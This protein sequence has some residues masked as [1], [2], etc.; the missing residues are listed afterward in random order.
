MLTILIARNR[1]VRFNVHNIW[2]FVSCKRAGEQSPLDARI[3]KHRSVVKPC[4]TSGG[5]KGKMFIM[6]GHGGGP[7]VE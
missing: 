6:G 4:V 1:T 5:E 2:R 3:F 7:V